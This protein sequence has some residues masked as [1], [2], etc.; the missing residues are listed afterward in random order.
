MINLLPPDAKTQIRAA[1]ANRL[2]LQYNFLLLG[3]FVFLLFALGIVHIYLANT[4]AA[5]EATIVYNEAKV[6]DYAAIRS[7]TNEFRQNLLNAKQILDNDITYTKAILGIAQV[8]PKGVVLDT[9]SLDAK[10][11]GTPTTLAAKVKDYPTALVLKNSL[12]NS[13]LFSNVSIQSLSGGSDSD[14]PLSVTLNVTIK[15]DAAQ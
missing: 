5:A 4:K 1:R 9:L 3:A 15:K 2:L 8:L 10:A 13:K 6:S 7:Q 14:Y 11:F 12:Q